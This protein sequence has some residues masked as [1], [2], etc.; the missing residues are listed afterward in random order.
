M[1]QIRRSSD[2][3]FHIWDRIMLLEDALSR[4]RLSEES[5]A[6][7]W[8]I[9]SLQADWMQQNDIVWD[10]RVFSHYKPQ[11]ISLSLFLPASKQE[12]EDMK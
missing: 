1:N 2:E 3:W 4:I 5:G 6:S 7:V 9:K 11:D 10:R 12:K 8:I